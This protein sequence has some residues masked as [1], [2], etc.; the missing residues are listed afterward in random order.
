MPRA[1]Q[2]G[3]Y[4]LLIALYRHLRIPLKST[5]YSFSFARNGETAFIHS[6]AS[7]LSSPSL[8]F[9]SRA[10]LPACLHGTIRWIGYAVCYLLLLFLA[11]LSW[12]DFSPFPTLASSL[13]SATLW[14]DFVNTIVVPLFSAVGTITSSDVLKLPIHHVLE[15]IHATLGTPHYS[16]GT[17]FSAA[18]VAARLSAPIVQQ[19][20]GHLRLGETVRGLRVTGEGVTV[21]C[22][23][24]DFDVDVVVIATQPR[25][26]AALLEGV[27]SV[28]RDEARRI[29]GMRRALERVETRVSHCLYQLMSRKQSS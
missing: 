3:Y 15:Y 21:E 9:S 27:Q 1:E 24:G 17:G 19:G 7:G 28:E 25:A 6:G 20:V 23:S 4:P 16:L 22:A 5:A 14:R 29:A 12:H 13:S 2:T 18:T 8:P 10:S 26:A 11:L